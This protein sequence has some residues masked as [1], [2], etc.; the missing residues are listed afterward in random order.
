MMIDTP[1]PPRD[2]AD[3]AMTP[4]SG[5]ST[6]SD[7]AAR[8]CRVRVWDPLVRLSHWTLA[9]SFTV[10]FVTEDDLLTVHVR[11]GYL[12]LGLVLFRF[13]WGFAGPRHARWSDFVRTPADIAAYLLDAARFRA[14]RY[15]GHNPA[16]GVMVVALLLSL[17]ATG[18]SGLAL[19]E[20]RDVSATVSGLTGG[21]TSGWLDV[22]E[23]VHEALANLTLI[24]VVFHL[25]GVLFTSLQ[26]GENLAKSMLTGH[27]QR[28]VP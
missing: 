9:V 11:A 3:N 8:S 24:L 17:A 12:I 23:D 10:A 5:H 21:D 22:L 18:L 20:A 26:H 4:A 19:Y 28:K 14:R 7:P 2:D 25:A 16:G 13:F 6:G 15:L 1:F 27:K